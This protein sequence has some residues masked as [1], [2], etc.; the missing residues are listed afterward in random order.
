MKVLVT[1]AN[2]L[3]GS[4]VCRALEQAGHVP[5]ALVRPGAN[6]ELLPP[7]LVPLEGDFTDGGAMEALLAESAPE[8][9]VHVAA[10]VSTGRP[11]L[12][13]SLAVNVHGTEALLAAAARAGVRRWVQISSMSAHPGNASVYGATKFAAEEAV[14]ASDCD[15][16]VLRPS[17]V[18][19][20][21]RRG[22]FFKLVRQLASLPVIPLPGGGRFPLRPVHE[23][24]L[25]GAV[26]AALDRPQAVGQVYMLGGPEDW[27]Y[28]E[29]I[30]E[31]LEELGRRTGLLDVPMALCRMGAMVGEVLLEE[32]PL[33]TDNLEGLEKAVAVDPDP[34][35]RDLGFNPRPYREGFR[36]CLASGLLGK[37]GSEAGP[38]QPATDSGAR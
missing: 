8:A 2:G 24:D 15:W 25:A 23:E 30:Q 9:I 20:P 33:T 35:R 12:E 38:R 31:T 19:G 28:R 13:A 6:T 26:V 37:G 10:V 16:T 32:P 27:T 21:R 14:R 36:Q 5:I 18:Y 7:A 22:I 11:D 4:A 34:A 17:L 1:G 3:V 29:F